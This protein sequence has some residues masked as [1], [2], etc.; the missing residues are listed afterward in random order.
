[1]S[2]G[3]SVWSCGVL[4]SGLVSCPDAWSALWGEKSAVASIK[5]SRV[6]ELGCGT[7]LVGIACAMAGASHVELTDGDTGILALAN[8]NAQ[9]NLEKVEISRVR[10]SQHVWGSG[11]GVRA[12]A[13]FATRAPYDIIVASDC[14]Y[15]SRSLRP[16][17][18]SLEFLARRGCEV[19]SDAKAAARH[20]IGLCI[21]NKRRNRER[22][23]AFYALI[24]K[25]TDFRRVRSGA[26]LDALRKGPLAAFC[27]AYPEAADDELEIVCFV[28]SGTARKKGNISRSRPTGGRNALARL[29][30]DLQSRSMLHAS[31][32]AP[33]AKDGGKQGSQK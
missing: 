21:A 19:G 18:Q 7:G 14:I 33:H 15:E 10:T 6:L 12:R 8:D 17:L 25:N 22:D 24:E 27:K 28:C 26:S 32:Q 31:R 30:F 29:M 1:M 11:L 5:G 3:G 13:P 9:R 4:M 2:T 16:L 20:L 23:R